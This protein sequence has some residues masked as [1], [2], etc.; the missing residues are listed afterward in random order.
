MNADALTCTHCCKLQHLV[1]TAL[2]DEQHQKKRERERSTRDRQVD[3]WNYGQM[4]SGM[5]VCASIERW[6]YRWMDRQ[7]HGEMDRWIDAQT[8]KQMDE[9]E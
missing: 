8:D 9:G 6:R 5:D 1:P 7:V 4:A 3:G 2:E